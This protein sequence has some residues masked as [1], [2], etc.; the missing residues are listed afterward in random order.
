MATVTLSNSGTDS[1]ARSFLWEFGEVGD[2]DKVISNAGSLH[3]ALSTPTA[4][5]S[6]VHR[7]LASDDKTGIVGTPTITP[8]K[9]VLRT[10]EFSNENEDIVADVTIQGSKLVPVSDQSKATSVSVVFTSDRY[11]SGQAHTKENLEQSEKGVLKHKISYDVAPW[12]NFTEGDATAILTEQTVSI[13]S[14]K[15]E[16]SNGRDVKY[17]NA[18]SGTIKGSITLTDNFSFGGFFTSIIQSYTNKG[19]NGSEMGSKLSL[20][21]KKGFALDK[22]TPSVIDRLS[23]SS[24]DKAN[25]SSHSFTSS[26]PDSELAAALGQFLNAETSVS[27]VAAVMFAGNDKIT[28]AKG[29]NLLNGYGGNDTLIGGKGDDVFLFTSE[30]NSLTNVERIQNF[31]KSGIDSIQLSRTIFTGYRGAQDFLKD[32]APKADNACIVYNTKT[33]ALFYDSDGSGNAAPVQF[34]VLVGKVTLTAADISL[35]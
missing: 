3:D 34:A 29:N 35:I 15:Y 4:I 11:Q 23:H 2:D 25:S 33:G 13:K 20:S 24:Y 32:A 6:A 30:L 8:S 26:G 18:F 21:S 19:N 31:K 27:D 5:V 22:D 14:T 12:G 1:I 7:G 9:I 10:T 28:S 17:D 16:N